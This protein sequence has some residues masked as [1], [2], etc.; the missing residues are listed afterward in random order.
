M[1][2]VDFPRSN[3][4]GAIDDFNNR[5]FLARRKYNFSGNKTRD[6]FNF[7]ARQYC[8]LWKKSPK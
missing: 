4:L 2:I 7:A 3:A 6:Y 1:L 8:F 5:L